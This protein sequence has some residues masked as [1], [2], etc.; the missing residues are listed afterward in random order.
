MDYLHCVDGIRRG[1][2]R[3]VDPSAY[4]RLERFVGTAGEE[5]DVLA[6]A[7]S[8]VQL[9]VCGGVLRDGSVVRS[10]VRSL[11]C[12]KTP[13][14]QVLCRICF[15][16]PTNF[17]RNSPATVSN[18]ELCSLELQRFW[19]LLN[20]HAVELRASFVWL[21]LWRGCCGIS[22]ACAPVV[23]GGL[24][25]TKPSDGVS[26]ACLALVSCNSP[27]SVSSSNFACN[28]PEQSCLS[29]SV[30]VAVSLVFW[31]C[32]R[33]CVARAACGEDFAAGLAAGVCWA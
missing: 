11:R 8:S 25:D 31:N 7:S 29:V 3:Q 19:M 23:A 2:D 18:I 13:V 24:R 33:L 4:L 15:S 14:G 17:A 1:A 5:R 9:S 26:S 10:V 12:G 28:S 27:V 20:V 6:V 21:W 16:M 32:M 30:R 22:V